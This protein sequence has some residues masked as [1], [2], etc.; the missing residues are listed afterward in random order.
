MKIQTITTNFTAGELSPRLRGRVDIEKF[1]AG[2]K[3]ADNV[4][5]LKQGGA[6]ARPPMDFLGEV[7][8]STSLARP[9]PFV[10]S[11]TTSYVLEFG[12]QLMR[13]WKQ[14]ALVES[15]QG[16]PFMLAL[17]YVQDELAALDFS[18]A[19]D[20]MII[21]HPDHAPHRLRRFGD[22][23]WRIE[24][25]PFKPGPLAEIGHRAGV[26]IT[27]SETTVGTDRTASAAS[28][29]FAAADVGRVLSAGAGA[30]RVT[31]VGSGTSATLE[32]TSAFDG[33]VLAGNAWLLEGTPL[34]AVKPSDA[35]ADS[36][37]DPVG[38]AI[39][40]TG[41]ID[42]WRGDD[43]GRYVEING[44]LVEI[45]GL[46]SALI[47]DG[48]IRR[49]LSATV[50]AIADGWILRG[51]AWNAVDGYPA[52]GTLHQGRLW[53]ANTRRYPNTVWGSM[54]GA[55]YDFTPGTDD[56]SAVYKTLD[57]DEVNPILFLNSLKTLIP[58]TYRNEFEIKGGVEK[59]I[60]QTNASVTPQ[61][62]WGCDDVR[63][64]QV[65]DNVLFVQR[66]GRVM[67]ALYALEIEGYGA[68]DISI[69][70]EHLMQEGVRCLSFQQA[71]ESVVWCATGDG[72]IV[73]ITY[74]SEQK[75]LAFARGSTEGFLEWIV[76]V[77]EG[78]RDATYLLVRREV[79][80]VQRRFM[81][82]LNWDAYPGM[83][84]RMQKT[85]SASMAWGGF[86]HLEGREVAVLADDVAMGRFTVEG[87]VITLPRSAVKVAVGLPYT[88][89]LELHAPELP[90]RSGTSQGQAISTNR[91]SVRLLDTIGCTANAEELVFR[92][93]GDNLLDRAP[94]PFSGI[95]EVPEFGWSTEDSPVV[96]A[97]PRPYPWTVLAVI[98]EITVNAG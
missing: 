22:A 83:D 9:I 35:A 74:S 3:T 54:S 92:Y 37:I 63:P 23:N 97:Q 27:L 68:N 17:P 85:G 38:S 89:T 51:P 71:P 60:T 90:T 77:P 79:G 31:A 30:A 48:I 46:T 55:Y 15:S 93:F 5:I 32:I 20:T 10:Y 72:R 24:E 67:R 4:V 82:R 95:K 75:V 64:E 52:T 39:T 80:G 84:A 91:I 21:F 62:H 14:G 76:T 96:L 8:D 70:S 44:G 56:D 69:F 73:A 58:L 49:E 36:G 98:R 1:N 40:L 2:A 19:A 45:I 42:T 66:G 18:H 34:S 50:E 88:P 78:R 6:T 28:V 12:H 43:V 94:Q 47:A 81:E 61:T 25:A 87:G 16:V 41:S 53:A 13:V 86:G 59:P 57:S 65:G 7:H 26:A 33:A 29:V 11:A